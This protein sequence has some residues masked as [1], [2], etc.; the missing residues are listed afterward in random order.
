[1]GRL[2]MYW[3]K[4]WH[5][6]ATTQPLRYSR[7]GDYR[8]TGARHGTNWLQRNLSATPDGETSDVPV[9]DMAQTSYNTT[10]LLLQMGRLLMYRYKTWHKLATTQPLRYSRWGDYRCTGARHGT[11]W[12]Q[13]N[14]SATP[15][16][17]TTDVQVQDMAQTGY[18]TTSPL[19]QMGRLLMY[20]YKTWHK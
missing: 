7:W 5:K 19:L 20:R 6:L 3:Y 16:G 13:H 14:L 17:E 9:Q 11:N 4:T 8:C 18:N 12:L 1:M 15:D 2:L 10:S